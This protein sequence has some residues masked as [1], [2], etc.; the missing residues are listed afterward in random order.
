MSN[1]RLSNLSLMAELVKGTPNVV[2]LNL[3]QNQ[4]RAMEELDKLKGWSNLAELVLDGNDVCS[5]Y[6]KTSYER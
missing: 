3:G 1:N 4:V 6:D 2:S 5:K